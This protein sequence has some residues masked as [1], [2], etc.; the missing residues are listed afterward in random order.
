MLV[1]SLFVFVQLGFGQWLTGEFNGTAQLFAYFG[2]T[3]VALHYVAGPA[4]AAIGASGGTIE[5]D[6]ECCLV[7]MR[8]LGFK[9][10]FVNPL[11]AK[12]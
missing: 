9:T 7:G 4:T 6:C 10:E 3:L 11:A 2:G 1:W 12:K 5:E 8:K